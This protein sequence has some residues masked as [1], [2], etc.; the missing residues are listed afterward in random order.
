ML[1]NTLDP[2]VAERPEEFIVCGTAGKTVTDWESYLAIGAA[3]RTLES[4]QTLLVRA[5]EPAKILPMHGAPP[6]VLISIGGNS[7]SWM[8]VGTQG[9]LQA[10]Y[11]TL[12]AAAARH[13]AGDLAGRLVVSAG[14]GSLGG[15][16]P[17]A[18]TWNGAAF[19]GIDADPA[20]IKRRVKSGYCDVMV[21]SLDEALRILKNAVRERAAR[22]VGLVGN[23]ADVIPELARRGVVPDLLTDRTA[24][25]DPLLGYW[26]RGMS[27]AEA[28]EL[29]RNN[30]EEARRRSL[31]SIAAQVHGMLELRK[32]GAMVFD[33][34]NGIF[35]QAREAGVSE[36]AAISD[37]AEANFG[38][39]LGNDRGP[40]RWIALSGEASDIERIDRLALQLLE[41]DKILV[42]Y[43]RLAQK[44][45]RPQGLP[46][47]VC[48]MLDA[49]RARFCLAVNDLVAHGELKAPIV[50]GRDFVDGS[51]VAVPARDEWIET[52]TGASVVEYLVPAPGSGPGDAGRDGAQAIVADGMPETVARIERVMGI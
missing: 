8:Y 12:R 35:A 30:P 11:E 47:R 9:A 7:A 49:D 26:P 28:A 40:L 19:L 34:G 46:A 15:A 42:R 44:Y 4:D 5:G 39:A 18:A 16:Q 29:R 37:F 3:L 43:I 31:E 33:F 51:G 20:R 1:M 41:H 22:S 10:T 13:F 48:W 32:L 23:A 36:A 17:L 24:E 21:S 25:Y 52:T 14:M 50:L 38:P 6:R 27:L 2:D 45:L